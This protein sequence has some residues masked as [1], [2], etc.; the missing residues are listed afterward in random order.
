M[1]R[2]WDY[3]YYCCI[4]LCIDL[5]LK[6]S[7]D[8]GFNYDL[9]IV[10]DQ[11]FGALENGTW[12]G[13][14]GDILKGKA[15]AS[16]A[17]LLDTADRSA[18]IDTSVSFMKSGISV[19]V[20]KVE[21]AVPSDA[22]LAPFDYTVWL[23]LT[24]GIVQAVALAV[25]LFECFSPGGYDR[26]ISGPRVS[27]FTFGS[28]L[29]IV[30]ALLFNNTVPLK[31]PRSYT[32]KFMTN[33]WGCFSLIFIAM[34]TANLVAHMIREAPDDMV[35]GFPDDRLQHP[36][37]YSHPLKFG[38]I[39]STSV[40]QYI[41]T[42]NQEMQ[43]HMEPY[44]FE[45]A[46]RAI[47]AVKSGFMDAFIYDEA[48]LKDLAAKDQDC[49]LHVVGK[50]VGETGY[51]IALTKGSHWT[52]SINEMIIEYT[53]SGFIQTLVDKWLTSMCDSKLDSIRKP[54]GIEHSS[55]VFMLL[56]GGTCASVLIFFGEH[57]FFRFLR[58]YFTKKFA[59]K[60]LVAVVAEAMAQS[61]YTPS[62]QTDECPCSNWECQQL[63]N[64]LNAALA[65]LTELEKM[66]WTSRNG[67]TTGYARDM[68]KGKRKL[69]RPHWLPLSQ[70]EAFQ[71]DHTDERFSSDSDSQTS[72]K[73]F[74][75]SFDNIDNL[76]ILYDMVESSV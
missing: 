76:D 19:L 59:K 30:W 61:I 44:N 14:V 8:L 56:L 4:G 2:G 65:R 53:D 54:L 33:M 16:I 21:G 5:L 26:N 74:T 40:E 39:R 75:N 12:N 37:H 7:E 62:R 49:S 23:L 25:F 38:T 48:A 31:P 17:T 68:C 10:D 9:Y 6:L 60:E 63:S 36:K 41:K 18:V 47:E 20:K 27:K 66:I 3:V 11:K 50:T 46:P 29:W 55:G 57:L 51:T 1:R 35:D 32:A 34:Y 52:H 64:E 42:V 13:I 70:N 58:N 71:G 73:N 43:D 67:S 45:R 28:S 72:E 24:V 22:F 15:D 69:D